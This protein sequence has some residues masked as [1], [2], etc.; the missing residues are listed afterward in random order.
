MFKLVYEA[1]A[2]VFFL[3]AV[4][5]PLLLV[6]F[7]AAWFRHTSRLA[8]MK[9]LIGWEGKR[10]EKRLSALLEAVPKLQPL[11]CASCG[12]PMVLEDK[13]ARCIGCD[14]LAALP[15]DYRAT[16]KLRRRLPRLAAAAIRH[17]RVA[18][19]LTATPVRWLLWL[20][21]LA[22][23]ALFVIILIGAGTY[24][25]TFLDRA[26][27]SI[28]EGWQLAVTLFALTAFITWMMVFGVLASQS[29]DLQRK[30]PAFPD[31]RRTT[32]EPEFTTC[33]SCGGGIGFGRGQLASLC[34]Y[35][36]VPNF[37]AGHARRDRGRSEDDQARMRWSLFGAME[38]IEGFIATIFFSMAI[39]LGTFA[40]FALWFLIAGE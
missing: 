17:W 10:K 25:N 24:R 28:D 29:K 8:A 37:R 7:G 33:G 21:I 15:E 36:T 16:R 4:L 1:T 5:V 12:S 23:P 3:Q 2:A 26:V 18:W 6:A 31:F 34:S 14:S 27:N 9:R 32:T 19:I 35:C 30:L 13:S 11:T 22:P 38:I 20:M 39:M 40:F